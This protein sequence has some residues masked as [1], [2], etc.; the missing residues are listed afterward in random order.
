MRKFPALA[1]IL[2]IALA[3]SGCDLP[4]VVV[5]TIVS[6]GQQVATKVAQALTDTAAAGTLPSGGGPTDAP[7]PEATPGVDPEPTLTQTMMPTAA[8]PHLRVAFISGGSPWLVAPPAAAYPLS[9]QTGVDSVHISDDGQMVAYVRHSDYSHPGE[10]R[11]VNYDASGDRVLLTSAQV[12]VLEALP[13]GA[14]FV[15]L[16]QVK[17]IP[18]THNLLVNTKANYDGPGLARFDDGFMINAETGALTTIF[19]AGNGGEYWPSPDGSK[20]VVSR[21]TK[22]ALANIDGSGFV[23]NLVTFPAIITYSEYQ[24]YPEPVWKADSS[25]FGVVIASEDPLAPVTS[26]AIYLV[27]PATSV[28]TLASTLTGNFFFPK[29]VLSPI[30]THV[31]YVTPTADPAV[32][33]SH[34]S[35]LDGSFGLH[36]GTGSTGVDTFSPD[37]QHFTYYVGSGTSDYVG[38][39]GGGTI[40]IPGGAM[41][42]QWYNNTHFVYASGTIAG[43]WNIRTGDT[44]GGSS[45]IATPSGDRTMFDAD[46]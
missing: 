11:V 32:K 1:F 29:A 30:L 40:L 43:G 14:T 13:A 37:G 9:A 10:L 2:L 45:V 8:L 39:L 27:N 3:V 12:G 36:L 22:I 21:A 5:S 42:L 41:R 15:D 28:A 24:Y 35:T 7:T 20:M 46:E 44:G 26:G 16:F 23:D 6:E 19:S 17:W 31:G 25:Q 34:V 33:D 18:G 38:S 4:D